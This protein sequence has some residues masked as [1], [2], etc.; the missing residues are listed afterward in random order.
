MPIEYAAAQKWLNRYKLQSELI[1]RKIQRIDML[2]DKAYSPGSPK[3]DGMP[4]N[5]D[6]SNDRYGH[7]LEVCEG[8]ENELSGD[9]EKR[10]MIYKQIDSMIKRLKGRGG[11]DMRLV[12]QMKYLDLF[13][14]SDIID[15]LFLDKAD[16]SDKEDSYRRRTFKIHQEG[17]TCL[18]ALMGKDEL[19]DIAEFY[20]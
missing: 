20:S 9:I 17:I 12:L 3:I 18:S 7:L 11:A 2:K 6:P 1:D 5:K 15:A 19:Q 13:E 4:K 8:I 14:W 10:R 16:F